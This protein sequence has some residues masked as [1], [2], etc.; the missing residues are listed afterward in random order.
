[1]VLYGA[2]QRREM[3]AK[4]DDIQLALLKQFVDLCKEKPHLLHVPQ[5]KFFKDWLVR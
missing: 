5:L 2:G 4:F 1:V 3:A